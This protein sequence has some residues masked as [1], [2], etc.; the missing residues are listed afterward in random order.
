LSRKG[1][2]TIVG[3]REAQCHQIGMHLLQRLRVMPESW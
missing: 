3:A 2:N 1:R